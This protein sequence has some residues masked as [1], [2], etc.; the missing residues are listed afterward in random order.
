[1][2]RK[3]PTVATVLSLTFGFPVVG[4]DKSIN[5]VLPGV[6]PGTV[7]P[8]TVS[9]YLCKPD[10]TL[11][12]CVGDVVCL[13]GSASELLTFGFTNVECNGFVA[14]SIG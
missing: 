4:L 5:P 10:V 1:M 2:L 7:F 11:P 6:V 9:P 14:V 13:F 3:S 8:S 12:N